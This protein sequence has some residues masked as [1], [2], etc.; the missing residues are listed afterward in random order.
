MLYIYKLNVYYL[1]KQDVY[2]R[3][4]DIKSGILMGL[5]LIPY[6]DAPDIKAEIWI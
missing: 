5:F 4:Q 3:K 6:L 2:Y 1:C